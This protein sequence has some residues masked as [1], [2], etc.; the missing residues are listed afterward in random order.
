MHRYLS[1]Y[2]FNRLLLSIF[3]FVYTVDRCCLTVRSDN[4]IC[5]AI[6]ALLHPLLAS[7]AMVN[8]VVVR[9]F[10]TSSLVSEL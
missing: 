6:S 9:L 4:R 7:M 3:N 1:I 10:A 5:S 2:S 8:S